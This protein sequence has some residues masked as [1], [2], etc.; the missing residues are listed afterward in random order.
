MT[1]KWQD[2]QE[3]VEHCLCPPGNGVFTVNT[4]K[5]RKAALH[6]KLYGQTENIEPLWKSSLQDLPTSEHK[7]VML[8]I[9]SDCGGG[10]LRGA[11]WGPL[12]LRSTLI[13]QQPQAKAFDIGDV[14]VIPHLLHDKYLNEGTI[15]N[16]QKALY[17]NEQSDY[18]VSPLSIT[19]D[20]C[21][22]FYANFPEKGIFGI[23]GDHSISYPLTKA[24]LKAKREQGKKVAI[25]HFD[26]HT[27]LL[28]ERLGIDLCF[29]SWCTHI[30]EF[31]PS[32]AH[33]IQFGIR[34]S[35]KP[36]EHW[37]STFGVKQHWAHEINERGCEAVI[38]EVL[39]QLRNDGVDELYVSFD[40]DALDAE[41]ASATGT[42]EDDGLNPQQALTI[43]GA[44]ADEFLI[45][46][47]DMMEIAPFTD[48][49]L[50]GKSSSETTLREGAKISAFLL[51]AMN[52]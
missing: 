4:A 1:A 41:F 51:Q 15:S 38:A 29:G 37:E 8:G 21:T 9:S 35:G 10:I 31:L 13:E 20:V 36:K 49:S 33:L 40:I 42:P 52:K 16:C 28:V 3:K 43:L 22:D 24:Y 17:A 50:E 45:T 14:R 46:G 19:E 39:Q 27:D 6:H 18:H 34:S 32:P 26:A 2:F 12:F 44:L 23:G 11:N 48:S 5:E 30:L 47:A 7:A 25:I